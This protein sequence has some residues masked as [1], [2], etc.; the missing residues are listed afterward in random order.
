MA[1]S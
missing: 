1:V